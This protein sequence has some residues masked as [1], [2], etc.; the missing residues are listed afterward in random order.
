MKAQI[1][2][3]SISGRVYV[4]RPRGKS[5]RNYFKIEEYERE[6]AFPVTV[7]FPSNARTLASSFFLGMFGESVR[8]AGSREEF[9]KRFK[10]EASKQILNEIE[11]GISEAL[12]AS[13]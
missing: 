12:S 4:G 7:I 8:K 1:D 9:L 10:F 6:G 5:A 11:V 13:E 3:R 2:L